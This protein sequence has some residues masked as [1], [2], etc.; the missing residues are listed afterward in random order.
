MLSRRNFLAISAATGTQAA[1][2][3]LET[4]AR[5]L[6]SGKAAP[7]YGLLI[8]APN[9]GYTGGWEDFASKIKKPGYDGGPLDYLPALPYTRQPVAD[10]WEINK[11]MLDTLRARYS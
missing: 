10:Q 8:C 3:S 4:F 9:W 2:N 11:H 6:S 5:P 7:G 1:V